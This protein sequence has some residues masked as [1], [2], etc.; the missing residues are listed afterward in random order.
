MILKVKKLH[1]D[2]ILPSKK[3]KDDAGWDVYAKS[4][5]INGEMDC[6]GFYSKI[7]YIEYFTGI[8]IQPVGQNGE[9]YFTY[10]A[11]RSSISSSNLIQCNS[12]GLID[13][14]YTGELIVRYKY[15]A[16]PSDFF[17]I[18][19]RISINV[20]MDKIYKVGDKIAQLIVT[21][22][23]IV[24]LEPVETLDS[25]ERGSGGFGSTGKN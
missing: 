25:T 17:I 12:Y 14:G 23:E 20:N 9:K 24:D 6:N 3:N 16:D 1:E 15:I 22:Q 2:S 21:K 8:S 4:F 5:K 10:L 11:P 13:T 7:N 18:G 19:D